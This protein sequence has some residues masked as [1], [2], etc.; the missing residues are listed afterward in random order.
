MKKSELKTG[1]I[2]QNVDG[3]Y[4]KVLLNTV[5][6]DIIGGANGAKMTWFP[7]EYLKE[8]LTFKADSTTYDIVK[9][10]EMSCNMHGASLASKGKILWEKNLVEEIVVKLTKE[11][12]AEVSEDLKTIKVGCQN[13][14]VKKVKELLTLIEKRQD[15]SIC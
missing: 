6:G 12:S 15:D 9:V 10:W 2:I 13:I 4:G 3:C 7:M 5:N 8:D 1:M 11:Y 14:P